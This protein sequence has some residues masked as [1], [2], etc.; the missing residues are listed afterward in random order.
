MKR[1]RYTLAP[2]LEAARAAE[3]SAARSFVVLRQAAEEA[4]AQA[5]AYALRAR[6]VVADAVTRDPPLSAPR[7]PSAFVDRERCLAFLALRQKRA[8]ERAARAGCEC[9]TARAEFDARMRRRQT[10]EAHRERA[11][12]AYDR[13]CDLADAAAFDEANAGAYEAHPRSAAKERA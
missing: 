7:S 5:R 12:A 4:E 1:F 10:F 6:R 9:D 8:A 2:A 13:A 3:N 11:L